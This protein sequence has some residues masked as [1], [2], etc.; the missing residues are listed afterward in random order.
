MKLY[1][2]P[3]IVA[4]CLPI[5]NAKALPIFNLNAPN[6]G[7]RILYPDSQNPNQ[8]YYAPNFLVSS[9][10]PS[11]SPKF[12][13]TEYKTSL[14]GGRSAIVQTTMHPAVDQIALDAA[15]K[16]VLEIN[17]HAV[18]SA[19]PYLYSGIKLSGELHQLIESQDCDHTAGSIFDDISCVF[20]LTRRGR[21]VLLN[22]LR[23][24]SGVVVDF[25]YEISGVVEQADH[26]YINQNIELTATGHI[27]GFSE[28]SCPQ[29]YIGSSGHP[30]LFFTESQDLSKPT[31]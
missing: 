20:R 18:F 26:S 3:M 5:L 24:P 6:A 27:G 8:Y 14:L 17:P 1:R 22:S 7:N 2:L 30:I 19:L 4:L 12:V 23:S 13:Y 21:T 16:R 10:D 29:C 9:Y 28:K 31:D 15:E 25:I 11:G